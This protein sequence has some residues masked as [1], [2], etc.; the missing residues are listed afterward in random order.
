M[1]NAETRLPD[2]FLLRPII[3]RSYFIIRPRLP[4]RVRVA[5]AALALQTIARQDSGLRVTNQALLG[6]TEEAITCG[7]IDENESSSVV[8][9]H[10][11][12]R[13]GPIGG[14]QA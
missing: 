7:R 11:L 1:Q 14:G 5:L 4:G 12:G 2:A 3:L 9:V 6:E 13:S 10:C 8:A